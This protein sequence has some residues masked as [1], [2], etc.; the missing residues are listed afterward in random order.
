MIQSQE[1]GNGR[2]KENDRKLGG[3]GGAKYTA[4]AQGFPQDRGPTED[5]TIGHDRTESKVAAGAC[6]K[7][8]KQDRRRP[9]AL[10][11]VYI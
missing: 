4:I 2:Y 5:M 3:G 9:L 7:M 6:A 8:V 11:K 1:K 10:L